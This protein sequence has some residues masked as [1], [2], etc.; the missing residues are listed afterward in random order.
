MQTYIDAKTFDDARKDSIKLW[1][2][3]ARTPDESTRPYT[4]MR[5][6]L[7]C[8]AS[9]M[10]ILSL[11]NYDAAGTLIRSHEGDPWQSIVPGTLGAMVCNGA[12]RSN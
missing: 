1:V 2:K 3:E 4:L 10:R 9:R 6:E 12:C 8:D 7:N 5:F 11:T